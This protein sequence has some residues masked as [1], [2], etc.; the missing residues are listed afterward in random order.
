MRGY[1]ADSR[2]G[3][4]T[5][6]TAVHGSGGGRRPQQWERQHWIR[7]RHLSAGHP[8]LHLFFRLLLEVGA[9]PME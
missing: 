1:P 4:K 5:D 8:S 6:K 2:L 3:S 9:S 7:K